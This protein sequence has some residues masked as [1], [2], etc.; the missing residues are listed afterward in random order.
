MVA[1]APKGGA[2]YHQA[3][4]RGDVALT[5]GQTPGCIP[6][7]RSLNIWDRQS[8]CRFITRRIQ[9]CWLNSR[10][11]LLPTRR[12][13]QRSVLDGLGLTRTAIPSDM[14]SSEYL[15][16][17]YNRSEAMRRLP[18]SSRTKYYTTAGYYREKSLLKLAN[19]AKDYTSRLFVRETSI[20]A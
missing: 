8:T 6:R 19:H 7:N 11:V 14:Y 13:T 4:C 3:R 5:Y 2:N 1:G 16:K 18:G 20:S 10:Q 9:R 17:A 15:R 12:Q